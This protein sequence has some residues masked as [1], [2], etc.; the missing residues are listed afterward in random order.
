MKTHT[1]GPWSADQYGLIYAG[2]NR[3]H[4]AKAVTIGLGHAA[5]AN[6]RLLAA[7]PALLAALIE[8]EATTADGGTI[9]E[10]AR[11]AIAQATGEQA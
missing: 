3:L 4:I 11:A 6:A 2:K 10:I 7:A 1:P 9:N 8:I 5:D